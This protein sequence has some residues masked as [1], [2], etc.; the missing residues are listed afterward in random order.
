MDELIKGHHLIV[1]KVTEEKFFLRSP[2]SSKRVNYF[3]FL[4][5]NFFTTFVQNFGFVMLEAKWR[6]VREASGLPG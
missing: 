5:A 1:E 6:Y 2:F 3:L 4:A